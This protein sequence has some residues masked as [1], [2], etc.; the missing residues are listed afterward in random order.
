MGNSFPNALAG[1]R[2]DG[3][4]IEKAKDFQIAGFHLEYFKNAGF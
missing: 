4:L 2:N 1:P 3:N